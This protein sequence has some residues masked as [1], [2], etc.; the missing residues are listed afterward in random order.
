MSTIANQDINRITRSAE[1]A[2]VKR[3]LAG[4]NRA[5]ETLLR[6]AHASN[7]NA[8]NPIEIPVVF[9][10][11]KQLAFEAVIQGHTNRSAAEVSGLNEATICRY[12]SDPEWVSAIESIKV[13]RVRVA[14]K[15]LSELLPLSIK[16]IRT[17]LSDPSASHRDLLKAAEMVLDRTGIPKA[18]RLELSG[19]VESPSSVTV[20]PSDRLAALLAGESR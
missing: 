3:A 5:L 4:D 11:K 2:L 20:D 10:G 9:K 18:E 1:A 8:T 6:R 14:A 7:S 16:R 17:V 15:G 13:Q 19:T 12:R